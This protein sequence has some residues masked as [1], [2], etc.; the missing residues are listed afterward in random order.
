MNPIDAGILIV[1]AIGFIMG[2]AKG[3]ARLIVEA[4]ALVASIAAAVT[5]HDQVAV[6][7]DRNFRL[8]E[9]LAAFFAKRLS[10]PDE[11]FALRP[12]ALTPEHVDGL[13][14]LL[15]LPDPYA[16]SLATYLDRLAGT[17]TAG[18]GLPSAAPPEN[19]GQVLTTT[20]ATALV[21][22]LAF[23]LLLC[24][25]G[26]LFRLLAP[27]LSGAL[28]AVTGQGLSTLAGG[29]IGLL[30]AGLA[31]A[32]VLGLAVP[33]LGLTGAAAWNEPFARS[34]LA[35]WFLRVFSTFGPWT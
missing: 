19:V 33:V 29:V 2:A 14:N 27:L 10:L 35:T 24:L 22:G 21:Q 12:P 17:V 9:R 30:L 20:V 34:R 23:L 6:F 3:L 4:V 1:L 31:V 32:I 8:V 11:V 5:Y 18:T 26:L 13:V 25:V 15:R 7:L 28:T 16:T